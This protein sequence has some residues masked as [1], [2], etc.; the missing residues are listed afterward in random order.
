MIRVGTIAAGVAVVGLSAAELP[1]QRRGGG[2]HRG[3]QGGGSAPAVAATPSAPQSGGRAHAGV[4]APRSASARSTGELQFYPGPGFGTGIGQGVG[5]N[6][7]QGLAVPPGGWRGP[8]HPGWSGDG[9]WGRRQ[10]HGSRPFAVVLPYA[11]SY[12]AQSAAQP[13]QVVVLMMPDAADAGTQQTQIVTGTGPTSILRKP[14]S[15]FA[16]SR[17]EGYPMGRYPI[18]VRPAGSPAPRPAD[19]AAAAGRAVGGFVIEEFVGSTVRVRWPD[20]GR[21]VR[22]V[23][24]FVDDGAGQQIAWKTMQSGPFTAIFDVTSRT[25]NVGVTV[26]RPDGSKVTTLV[27]YRAH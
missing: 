9:R 27:P 11:Y 3:G 15:S 23:T 16:P 10:W 4:A 6:L 12:G 14:P 8:R 24:L 5:A 22:V 25:R 21:G 1:A 19:S 17:A 2:G 26:V 18:V 7:G 20:D 13:A